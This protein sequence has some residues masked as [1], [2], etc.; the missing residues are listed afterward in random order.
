MKGMIF[1]A[2]LGLL[3]M[4]TAAQA[5]TCEE[6]FQAVGDPRNGV[7]FV[8]QVTKPGLS[9]S[10]ALGQMQ[11]IAMDEGFEVGAESING[12]V[13]ELFFTQTTS[14]PPIVVRVEANTSGEVTMG[15]RLAPGQKMEKEAARQNICGMLG[16]LKTGK[17]GNQI[18]QAARAQTG[19]GQVIDAKAPELSAQIKREV[20]RAMGPVQRKGAF[21]DLLLGTTTTA[22]QGDL[23]AAFLPVRAKYMGRKYRIDGQIYTVSRD[24]YDGVMEVA[25]LV[26]QTRG[27]LGVRQSST[28][29]D[30]NFTINCV[31][32]KDQ[33]MFFTTLR[34]GDWVNLQGTVNT[35]NPRGM[36]LRDCRQA[37]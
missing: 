34:E 11:K 33:A 35:V 15:T 21:K 12:S 27:L 24:Q 1:V 23:A 31:L 37:N 32:S 13:G 9:V 7:M 30:L 6:M 36:V 22:A 16:R 10:S 14:R 4:S 18:A 25:Y 20:D 29:Q 3:A 28:Y 26:T 8:G 2:G 5:A 19:A 17:E